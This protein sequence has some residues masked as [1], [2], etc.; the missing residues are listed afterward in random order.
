MAERTCLCK[1]LS[2]GPVA[3]GRVSHA[4]AC[5]CAATPKMKKKQRTES[6]ETFGATTGGGLSQRGHLFGACLLAPPPLPKLGARRHPVDVLIQ[7]HGREQQLLAAA[8]AAAA[9]A[10]PLAEDS[11]PQKSGGPAEGAAEGCPSAATERHCRVAGQHA[12]ARESHRRRK[13]EIGRGTQRWR[14]EIMRKGREGDAKTG[15]RKV[16]AK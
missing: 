14:K 8:A 15:D 16:R 9:A 10:A 3:G 4:S 13:R 12:C 7:W 11:S 6:K 5:W 2:T 1:C